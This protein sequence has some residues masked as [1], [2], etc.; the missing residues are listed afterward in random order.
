MSSWGCPHEI[1]G[2]CARINNVRC[3][4]GMKG[5]ILFGRFIW[6]DE[7]K[8]RPAQNGHDETQAS[9]ETDGDAC[10]AGINREH[11]NNPV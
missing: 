6:A 5:C 9:A 7:T 10:L 4:P 11:K 3:D 2:H 1:D 8:N